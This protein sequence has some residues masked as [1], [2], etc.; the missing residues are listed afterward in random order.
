MEIKLV[1]FLKISKEKTEI[2]NQNA[3][4]HNNLNNIKKLFT[5]KIRKKK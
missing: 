2:K 5:H 1:K 3:D 4:E